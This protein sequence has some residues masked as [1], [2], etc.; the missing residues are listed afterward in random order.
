VLHN[1]AAIIAA[2]ATP[3]PFVYRIHAARIERLPLD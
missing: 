3:G 1:L 2:C